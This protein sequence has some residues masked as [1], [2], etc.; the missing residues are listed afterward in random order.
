[1]R[2]QKKANRDYREVSNMEREEHLEWCKQR[3]YEYL[4]GGDIN[5]A[6]GSFVS[7]M[8]KHPETANHPAIDLGGM[9]LITGNMQDMRRFIEGFN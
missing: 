7:D 3:A 6:Y 4:D 9:L 5:G 1:M 2:R 8:R